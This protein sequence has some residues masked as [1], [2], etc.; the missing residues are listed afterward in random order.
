M[1][2]KSFIPIK[3]FGLAESCKLCRLA[4]A[5]TKL[6]SWCLPTI[7]KYG[8]TKLHHKAPAKPTV[9]QPSGS[10]N[11]HKTTGPSTSHHRRPIDVNERRD[12]PTVIDIPVT[13][14]GVEL[15]LKELG[16]CLSDQSAL[17]IGIW[18]PAGVGKTTL[19]KAF[20]NTFLSSSH[21]FDV[22]IFASASLD[23]N[24]GRLQAAIAK[25]LGLPW[26]ESESKERKAARISLALEK[27]RCLL[28]L[29][30]IWNGLDLDD[31]GIPLPDAGNSCRVLFT[32]RRQEVCREMGASRTMRVDP[33]QPE[34]AWQLFQTFA[35][36]AASS[37]EIIDVAK[38]VASECDGLPLG[39]MTVGR[40]LATV[41]SREEWMEGLAALRQSKEE[42]LQ[43]MEPALFH[44]DYSHKRLTPK[45]LRDC[46]AYCSLFPKNHSIKK[47]EL[48][49]Y[50]LGEGFL[51]DS[52][53][54][55]RAHQ[56]AED[57][58]EELK[59]VGMLK[60]GDDPDLEVVMHDVLR[61]LI[62]DLKKDEFLVQAGIG[63][64]S[65][66]KMQNCAEAEKLSLMYN[67]IDELGGLGGSPKLT[68]LIL[69]RNAHFKKIADDSFKAAAALRLVDFSHTGMKAIPTGIDRLVQLRHLDLSFTKIKSLPREVGELVNL[70]Q[71][72]LE[73]TSKLSMI[74]D[75]VISKLSKLLV[76][77]MR[78]S[79]GNWDVEDGEGEV[80][81]SGASIEELERLKQLSD[82]GITICNTQA[83]ERFLK[84]HTLSKSTGLL[85]LKNCENLKS[86]HLSS[87][88]EKLREVTISDCIFLKELKIGG[89]D[90]EVDEGIWQLPHLEVLSLKALYQAEI[91][92]SGA[93]TPKCLPMFR[94]LD[95]SFCHGLKDI[96]WVLQLKHIEHINLD[97]CKQ[98]EEMISGESGVH[99]SYDLPR[100]KALT[101]RN[102]PKLKSL[103]ES[104]LSVPSLEYIKVLQCPQLT[105]LPHLTTGSIP[106]V[107]RGEKEWWNALEWKTDTQ[108]ISS[109]WFF[110]A[111]E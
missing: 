99:V 48:V 7:W 58:I 50:F 45:Q 75:N 42:F 69:K 16:N 71:L 63:L 46:I 60:D 51:D 57:Y 17:M 36:E 13:A 100:L 43:G 20:N 40:S 97:T 47:K 105:T 33:L 104:P 70:M 85:T 81:R 54:T 65:M 30:D 86:V 5:E 79:Y 84:S 95:I 94:K 44:F 61:D 76:L 6:D 38:D 28:I 87:G 67:Y 66:P 32:T 96:S 102:L 93:I 109:F 103:S 107:L 37:P 88:L 53:G 68:T 27:K 25:R 12:L 92:W 74:P 73:G 106:G 19:M 77:N 23:S 59:A 83:W 21:D 64:T 55:D 1:V 31:V 26:Q 56:K 34:V 15:R 14:L 29:D 3:L 91:I 62:L 110:Q 101:L 82:L 98:M 24:V 4:M 18:G 49:S 80:E 22:V 41:T 39:L 72:L 8:I 111:A 11:R 35:G 10:P 78:G 89:A 9:K 52:C 108:E 90:K 2:Y